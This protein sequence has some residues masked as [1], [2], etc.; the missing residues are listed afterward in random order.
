MSLRIINSGVDTLTL[1]IKKGTDPGWFE[2][3]ETAKEWVREN[4]EEIPLSL[5]PEKALITGSNWMRWRYHLRT[6][7]Y[8]I[9]VSPSKSLPEIFAQINSGAIYNH[10]IVGA[11]KYLMMILEALGDY[12][13]TKAS[14]VDLFCDTQGWI[15]EIKDWDRFVTRANIKRP[16]IEND[17][18]SSLNFGA[19]PMYLRMYNKSK[20]IK[21]RGK[22]ELKVVWE[23]SPLYEPNEPVVRVEYEIGREVLKESGVDCVE[24]LLENLRPI[25]LMALDWCS[26]RIPTENKQKSRWPVDPVWTALKEADFPGEAIPA[27]RKRKKKGDR[28]KML[29]GGG[30]YLTSYGREIRE[31]D[32]E[33]VLKKYLHDLKRHYTRKGTTFEEIVREKIRLSLT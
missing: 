22:E 8:N 9:G 31:E 26:L 2:T 6:A 15:P 20:E 7:D 18:L 33:V 5:G 4:N 10:G 12:K 23:R 25:W 29:V 16:V 17:K 1:S 30:G 13:F 19:F 3:L 28:K 11:Y 14:R 27:V 21:K 24:D 32:P